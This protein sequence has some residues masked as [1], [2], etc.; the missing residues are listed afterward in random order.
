M[1]TPA[2]VKVGPGLLYIAPIGTTEPTAGSG[3]L[4]SAWV[5]V[6]YTETGSEFDF[7]TSYSDIDVAEELD[8]IRIVAT[9]RVVSVKFSM[10]EISARN[11]SKALNGGTI[12]SPSSGFVTFEPPALGAETRVMLCW[13]SDDAQEQWLFRRC[14]STASVN[15]AHAKAPAK[16]LIPVEFRC[17]IP[18]DG[19]KSFKAWITSALAYT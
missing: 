5:A 14:L 8:P 18:T 2:A 17:E 7:T 13:Q 16:S 12:S 19:S 3:A 11:I 1:G 6:G 9:G 15:I 10:A 4:P